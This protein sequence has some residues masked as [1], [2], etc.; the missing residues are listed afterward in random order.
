MFKS[1]VQLRELSK[2]HDQ[3]KVIIYAINVLYCAIINGKTLNNSGLF[4]D[5]FGANMG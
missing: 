2:N 5:T 1:N 3:D 4:I